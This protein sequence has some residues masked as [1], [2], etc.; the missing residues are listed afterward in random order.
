MPADTIAWFLEEVAQALK[1]AD[2]P[3]T[4]WI[5]NEEAEAGW[6]KRRAVLLKRVN[7]DPPPY[8]VLR[9]RPK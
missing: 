7:G 2:D 1:E 9:D 5:S 6:A 4:V 3:N 8:C